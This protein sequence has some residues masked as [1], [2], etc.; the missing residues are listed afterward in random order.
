MVDG[1]IFFFL[2]LSGNKGK[3]TEVSRLD[4]GALQKGKREEKLFWERK[5][6]IELK[7]LVDAVRDVSPDALKLLKAK[8]Q[9]GQSASPKSGTP[10]KAKKET[11][12]PAAEKVAGPLRKT[13]L[14]DPLHEN[15]I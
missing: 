6:G 9:L 8:I 13:I 5:R 4:L 7:G 15:E 14:D 12:K 3:V 11:T 2:A 1:G 10:A